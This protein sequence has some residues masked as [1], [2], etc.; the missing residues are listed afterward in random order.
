MWINRN[1][2]FSSTE[3]SADW[4]LNFTDNE[5]FG[6]VLIFQSFQELY[7]R[8]LPFP[9]SSHQ[10]SYFL[11]HFPCSVNT[12][13]N[14]FERVSAV[15]I[16]KYLLSVVKTWT[17]TCSTYLMEGEY[18][19]LK[20]DIPKGYMCLHCHRSIYNLDANLSIR[21]MTMEITRIISGAKYFRFFVLIGKKV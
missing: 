13:Q 1:C 14:I 6:E 8:S 5:I 11:C 16:T 18:F 15:S 10:W 17:S 19:Q 20:K 21:Q 3:K 4:H 2:F 9:S 7:K 12:V